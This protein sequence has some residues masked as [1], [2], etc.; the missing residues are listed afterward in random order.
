[1]TCRKCRPSRK[2]IAAI[3]RRTPEGQSVGTPCIGA[4]QLRSVRWIGRPQGKEAGLGF[5]GQVVLDHRH[6]LWA[7]FRLQDPIPKPELGD[8]GAASNHGR[9]AGSGVQVKTVAVDKADRW[10]DFDVA[11]RHRRIA[12]Q[13]ACRDACVW[14]IWTGAQRPRRVPASARRSASACRTLFGWIKTM[15]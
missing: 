15:G 4:A 14:R 11:R 5:G 6:D 9:S 13:V 7:L 10:R 12:R 1:M 3:R 2:R 8:V